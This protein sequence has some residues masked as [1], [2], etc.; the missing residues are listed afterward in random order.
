MTQTRREAYY[1]SS[2]K[3]TRGFLALLKNYAYLSC[4]WS[5]FKF[6]RLRLV[7][8]EGLTHRK[9]AGS[10]VSLELELNAAFSTGTRD[11]LGVETTRR[12]LLYRETL[13]PPFVR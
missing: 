13:R 8:I 1:L 2:T 4:A 6:L 10:W 9:C 11:R 7:C 12:F 5:F 3:P